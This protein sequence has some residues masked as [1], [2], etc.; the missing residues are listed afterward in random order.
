MSHATVAHKWANQIGNKRTNDN[1]FRSGNMFYNNK[2][3]YSYGYHFA[4][5][6]RFDNL[7]L[8]NSKSYSSST[9]KHIGHTNS[10]IDRFTHDVLYVPF[11]E[12]RYFDDEVNLKD[13]YKYI[14][15]NSFVTDFN[16]DLKALGNARKPEIYL[17]NIRD[18]KDKLN[19]IFKRFRGSKTYAKKTKGINKLLNFEFTDDVQAKLKKLR[20]AE[21]DKQKKKRKLFKKEALSRLLKYEQGEI[22][23]TDYNVLNTLGLNT[24]IRVKGDKIET[25]KGMKVN[26]NEGVRIFK[27]WEQGKALGTTL[28]TIGGTWQCTKANGIIKFGCHEINYDQAKRVLTPYIK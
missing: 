14:D 4:I 16:K 8:L 22:Y 15:F 12:A 1:A 9:G 24:A 19:I 27:L 26:L 6:I 13:V 25:S 10:A 5:A 7:I 20:K 23:S 18:L 3:I 21:L 28:K 17:T 11:K 2:I